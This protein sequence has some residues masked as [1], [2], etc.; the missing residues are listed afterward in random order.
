[1][2]DT[3]TL[4]D[5]GDPIEALAA[6]IVAGGHCDARALDRARRVATETGERLD[7]VLK[8]LGLVAE[9]GL[10][11][12]YAALLGVPLADAAR[13]PAEPLLADRL[14]PRFL[15]AARALPVAEEAGALVLATADPLDPFT[16]RAVATAVGRDVRMEV[17]VPIELE[18]AL[19]RLYPEADAPDG[20][21]DGTSAAAAEAPVEEDTDRLQRSGERGA[22]DPP[23]QPDDR[24]RGRDPRLR[25]PYRAVRGPAARPLPL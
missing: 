13:Y 23:G 4:R 18:A 8:Q 11:E 15:R 24:P 19:D 6:L 20:T 17:A 25:H 1:M 22:G 10:A 12:A 14:E 5:D 21:P 2:P 16:P 3:M 7:R 9:R